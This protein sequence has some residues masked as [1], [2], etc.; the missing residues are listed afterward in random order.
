[1][2]GRLFLLAG[3]CL[4]ISGCATTAA[5]RKPTDGLRLFPSL[6]TAGAERTSLRQQ[7]EKDSFPSADQL[8]LNAGGKLADR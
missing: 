7:V 2:I 4:F 8:D 6:G 3:I 5:P 1:M